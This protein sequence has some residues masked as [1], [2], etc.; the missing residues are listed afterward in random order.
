MLEDILIAGMSVEG[1]MVL[2]LGLMV[3]ESLKDV[4][5]SS[6]GIQVWRMLYQAWSGGSRGSFYRAGGIKRR[7]SGRQ[8]VRSPQTQSLDKRTPADGA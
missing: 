1:M 7:D 5:R 2:V 6:D 4:G 3:R 8:V